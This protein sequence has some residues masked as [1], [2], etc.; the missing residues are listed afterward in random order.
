MNPFH[1]AFKV[2]DLES[3]RKFY[4]EILGCKEGRSTASWVDFD[5]FGNQL[6][7]HV[8]DNFP[9]L[10]YCGKVDGVSVP[11]PHFG[12]LIGV[13]EFQFIRQKFEIEQ[14]EFVVKP[15]TRYQGKTGEQL[16]MFVFDF[17]GNPLEFKAFS[18]ARE[19]FQ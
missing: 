2:K 13:E 15:Q 8:S 10:D 11:I 7:A 1:Y 18:D 17:S 4:V 14:I 3:T 6:S 9:V 19:V 16:T 12:C 5:F